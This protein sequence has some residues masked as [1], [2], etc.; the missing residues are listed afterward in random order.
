MQVALVCTLVI[1]ASSES[2]ELHIRPESVWIKVPDKILAWKLVYSLPGSLNRWTSTFIL[3]DCAIFMI[4]N[5]EAKLAFEVFSL[6]TRISYH[7]I[8]Y[9]II[10]YHIIS[11]HII[12]YHMAIIFIRSGL[13]DLIASEHVDHV[14]WGRC[15]LIGAQ[16]ETLFCPCCGGN[17]H[18]FCPHD[19]YLYTLWWESSWSLLV[20]VVVGI[21]INFVVKIITLVVIRH[22]LPSMKSACEAPS[23]P[24]SLSSSALINSNQNC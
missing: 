4:Y 20:H 13:C 5:G 3:T 9:R 6:C 11:Y 10:S 15:N 8:S 19:H 21:V 17:L 23:S 2:F 16:T 7:I 24:S 1:E 14:S 18:H 12:S 22:E